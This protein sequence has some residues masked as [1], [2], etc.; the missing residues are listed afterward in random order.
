MFLIMLS[1]YRW[2]VKGKRLNA[3]NLSVAKA[4]CYG[5]G[6]RKSESHLGG[7]ARSPLGRASNPRGESHSVGAGPTTCTRLPPE[8][9]HPAKE[10]RASSAEPLLHSAHLSV[11]LLLSFCAPCIRSFLRDHQ[12]RVE[13]INSEKRKP[14]RESFRLDH[15]FASTGRMKRG[16]PHKINYGS[17]LTIIPIISFADKNFKPLGACLGY[18]RA[19]LFLPGHFIPAPFFNEFRSL[20]GIY[21][22]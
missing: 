5:F 13:A 4:N 12:L 7:G 15:R 10:L 19:S 14:G 20:P 1:R 11:R 3:S 17:P 21:F 22:P 8:V 16:D 6:L 2:A 18:K 9:L